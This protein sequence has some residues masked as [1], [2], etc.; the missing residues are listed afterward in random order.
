MEKPYGVYEGLTFK[1]ERWTEVV[2]RQGIPWPQLASGKL[3]LSKEVFKVAAKQHP[4][5]TQY[6]EIRNTLSGGVL[7]L[8]VTVRKFL[9][10]ENFRR[11]LSTSRTPPFTVTIT[12]I[13]L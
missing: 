10:L 13:L 3:S 1:E 6:R 8:A 4:I 11:R 9:I 12:N 7:D 2:E 5:A